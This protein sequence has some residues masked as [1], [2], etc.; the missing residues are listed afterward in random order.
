MIDDSIDKRK[1]DKSRCGSILNGESVANGRKCCKKR[2]VVV[3]LLKLNYRLYLNKRAIS[4][5]NN[6]VNFLSDL[7]KV[8]NNQITRMISVDES[9]LV[10]FS[11]FSFL[12]Q[13]HFHVA[14][15]FYSRS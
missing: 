6:T 11:F 12:L 1:I 15:S 8:Y 9:K 7:C 5:F 4:M 3:N 10:F 14:M 13:S 2:A